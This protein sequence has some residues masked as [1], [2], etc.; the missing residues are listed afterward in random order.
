MRGRVCENSIHYVSVIMC[1]YAIIILLLKILHTHTHTHC[2][3]LQM[4]GKYSFTFSFE[5][6]NN[7][8]FFSAKSIV[9]SSSE[10]RKPVSKELMTMHTHCQNLNCSAVVR[11]RSS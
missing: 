6:R 11:R 10:N 9:K 2:M 7:E 3:N 1:M 4:L 8:D 5:T